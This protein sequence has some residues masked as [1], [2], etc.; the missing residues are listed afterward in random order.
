MGK[1]AADKRLMLDMT[2]TIF[3]IF[4]PLYGLLVSHL[5]GNRWCK[6]GAA[7][8]TTRILDEGVTESVMIVVI[9]EFDIMYINLSLEAFSENHSPRSWYTWYT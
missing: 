7:P 2:F 4:W 8:E 9:F 3:P 5:R 1:E 6:L